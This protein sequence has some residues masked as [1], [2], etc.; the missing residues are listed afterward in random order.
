MVS[1]S[2]T[3]LIVFLLV[4]HTL[5][6][7]AGTYGVLPSMSEE[8]NPHEL[9]VQNV[10]EKNVT[11]TVDLGGE[12]GLW[13]T[14]TAGWNKIW[15]GLSFFWGLLSAPYSIL[16]LAELPAMFENIIKGILVILE[17]SVVISYVW[18]KDF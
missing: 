6:Y 4:V 8:G 14:V 15:G 1:E 7:F 5:L 2:G 9:F 16:A 3:R 10:T 17:I 12:S 11:D 13:E 18:K